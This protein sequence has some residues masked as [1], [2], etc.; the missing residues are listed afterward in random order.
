MDKSLFWGMSGSYLFFICLSVSSN[1]F[2]VYHCTQTHKYADR[3]NSSN[4]IAIVLLLPQR[5]RQL[6][7]SAPS[8]QKVLCVCINWALSG[9]E[10]NTEVSVNRKSVFTITRTV[11]TSKQTYNMVG[12]SYI[13]IYIYIALS[14]G[15]L[16]HH[17]IFSTTAP[18]A[19]GYDSSDGLHILL[20]RTH[21]S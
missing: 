10:Q 12:V 14:T 11:L 15:F 6:C 8:A 16:E 9:Q 7:H 2:Q 20:D 5:A 13:Y 21:F 1:N 19:S 4:E 3:F 18:N 17:S